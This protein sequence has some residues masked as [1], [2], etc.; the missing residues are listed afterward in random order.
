MLRRLR[1]LFFPPQLP[2]LEMPREKWDDEYASRKWDYLEGL[3]ELARYSVIAGYIRHLEQ[4][5]SVLEIGCGTGLLFERLGSLRAIDYTGVDLSQEAIA[6]ARSRF[7]GP[8][9][10]FVAA[11]G[12]SFSDGRWYDVVVFNEALYYFNDCRAVLSHYAR[13]LN[14]GG[15]FIVSMVVGDVSAAH[16]RAIDENYRTL[17][18]VQLRN[19]KGI[20]WNCRLLSP[21]SQADARV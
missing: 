8:A 1:G 15:H 14:P 9:T 7:D 16:W 18:A 11:D 2:S 10:S 6:Q 4:C 12:H 19:G 5:R 21:S 13:R 20:T 3:P 17:D